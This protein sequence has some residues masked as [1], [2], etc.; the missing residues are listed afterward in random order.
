MRILI[1][2]LYEYN[3]ILKIQQLNVFRMLFHQQETRA[4]KSHF[5]RACN[6]LATHIYLMANLTT[7]NVDL[8]K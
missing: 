2:P 1:T 8:K 7:N 5:T 4:H 6:H 3:I